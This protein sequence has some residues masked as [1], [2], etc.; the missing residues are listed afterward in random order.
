MK[1]LQFQSFISHFMPKGTC[2]MMILCTDDITTLDKNKFKPYLDYAKEHRIKFL[3]KTLTL[4][5]HIDYSKEKPLFYIRIRVLIRIKRKFY[6][7]IYEI[8]YFFR[9]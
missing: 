7:S 5:I 4:M 2:L 8:I 1:S 6:S 9:K 3:S